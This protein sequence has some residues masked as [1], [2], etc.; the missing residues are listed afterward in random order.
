M[1]H[2]QSAGSLQLLRRFIAQ[3]PFLNCLIK[4]SSCLAAMG[5]FSLS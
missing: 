5:Y 1:T 4:S 2:H 3:N